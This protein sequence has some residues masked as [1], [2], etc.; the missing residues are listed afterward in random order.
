QV[1]LLAK[2]GTFV[3]R[4]VVA[5]LRS[6]RFDWLFRATPQPIRLLALPRAL[7]PGARDLRHLPGTRSMS[8]PSVRL[9]FQAGFSESPLPTF[10]S[11]SSVP[12]KF[13]FPA[14][15]SLTDEG[16]LGCLSLQIYCRGLDARRFP[17]SILCPI[18]HLR[19]DAY[20]DSPARASCDMLR[21]AGRQQSSGK[22][23][24]ASCRER[25]KRR[26]G[27]GGLVEST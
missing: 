1:L 27:T 6:A 8:R 20:E 23:G 12:G 21:S 4:G 26:G 15:P 9:A 24:R 2:T 22:I 19:R 18:G 5:I 13:V 25:V 17:H 16:P 11:P 14:I 10:R 3:A 7:G